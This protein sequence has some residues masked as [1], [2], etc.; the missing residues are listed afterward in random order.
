MF[1]FD[2][3]IRAD[4]REVWRFFSQKVKEYPRHRT[5]P[6]ASKLKIVVD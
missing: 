3:K 4:Q 2:G 6:M 5:F 1:A